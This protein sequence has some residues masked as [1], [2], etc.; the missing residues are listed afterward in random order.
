MDVNANS[1]LFDI[2]YVFSWLWTKWTSHECMLKTDPSYAN[3]ALVI[4]LLILYFILSLEFS[5][6]YICH[7]NVVKFSFPCTQIAF[8]V[9]S[10]EALIISCNNIYFFFSTIQRLTF[11][12]HAI[13]NSN[14]FIQMI[15][16][17][18]ALFW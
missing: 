10:A 2:N 12:I 7:K 4:F 15:W 11:K 13:Y 17:T 1:E 16:L 8:F 18:H 3:I 5:I 9:H 14:E 6:E